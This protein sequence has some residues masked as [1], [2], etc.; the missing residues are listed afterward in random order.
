[1][2][3]KNAEALLVEDIFQSQPVKWI[4][5]YEGQDHYSK[6]KGIEDKSINLAI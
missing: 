3:E 2:L 5:G 4:V 1:M 6:P